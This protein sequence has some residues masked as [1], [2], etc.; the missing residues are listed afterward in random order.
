MPASCVSTVW[1]LKL[2]G[3]GAGDIPRPTRVSLF[4]ADELDSREKWMVNVAINTVAAIVSMVLSIPVVLARCL[5]NRLIVHRAR[6]VYLYLYE[7][8]GYAVGRLYDL[9]SI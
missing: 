8:L 3:C 6:Y 9:G 4:Y 5:I 1:P 2:A 7:T